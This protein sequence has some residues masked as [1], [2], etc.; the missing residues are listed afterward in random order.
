LRKASITNSVFTVL[1]IFLFLFGLLMLLHQ[2]T[3]VSLF[4]N[5]LG[6]LEAL[7]L[8]GVT[9]FLVGTLLI[10]Q[11]TVRT[12]Y[13]RII[14]EQKAENKV[15]IGQLL[16][17]GERVDRLA[18]MQGSVAPIVLTEPTSCMF[19]GA[20]IESGSRFCPLCGKSQV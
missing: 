11:S 18:G 14:V 8:C 6:G 10:I 16:Q 4:S 15:V 20:R 5:I 19:C 12:I 7:E 3:V 17:I 9:L 2:T 1:G 13:E